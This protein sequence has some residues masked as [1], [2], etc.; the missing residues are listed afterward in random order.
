[1]FMAE[2]IGMDPKFSKNQVKNIRKSLKETGTV[3]LPCDQNTN[4]DSLRMSVLWQA[5]RLTVVDETSK[6]KVTLRSLRRTANTKSK[7]ESE[8]DPLFER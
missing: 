3:T 7:F 2:R 5:G 8:F 6:D 4:L 1:M